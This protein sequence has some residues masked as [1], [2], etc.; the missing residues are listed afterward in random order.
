MCHATYDNL[1]LIIFYD[2]RKMIYHR[3]ILTLS[4][5]TLEE[6]TFFGILEVLIRR[7]IC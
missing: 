3:R 7:K 4:K 5:L 6:Q 2:E 1:C